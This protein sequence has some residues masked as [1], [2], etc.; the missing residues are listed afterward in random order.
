MAVKAYLKSISNSVFAGLPVW[1]MTFGDLVFLLFSKY[2]K[3][4]VESDFG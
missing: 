2:S 4:S 3:T 1:G